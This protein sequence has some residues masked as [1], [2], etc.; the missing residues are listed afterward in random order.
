MDVK[1]LRSNFAAVERRAEFAVTYF[2]SHLFWHNPGVR[3]LFPDDIEGMERQRDR[4][5]AALTHVVTHIEDASLPRYLRDL[6]RDHRKFL[7][8]PEHYAAVGDSLLAALAKAAGSAWTPE[9]EKAWAEAYAMIADAMMAGAEE[10]ERAGEPP[11]WDAE[12]IRHLRYDDDIAV[13]TLRPEVP[14]P[15]TPGQYV[16]V[17]SARVP[18]TWRTYSIANAPRADLTLDLHISRV[19]GGRLSPVLVRELREG[20]V[21]R[22]GAA[23]GA[24]TLRTDPVRPVTLIAAGTGWSPVRAMIEELA[25]RP[26]QPEVRLFAVARDAAYLYDRPAIDAFHQECPWLSVS[27]ITP[28]PGR[29]G[30]EATGRLATALA[31]RVNWAAQDVYLS[32]PAGFIDEIAEVLAGLGADEARI[33]HDSVP[34]TGEERNRPLGTGGWFLARRD[35]RWHNPAGRAPADS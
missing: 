14:L 10:A 24:M 12:V 27:Y 29:P 5:F 22:L 4:L 26:T 6:G 17:S 25:R 8:A 13:L 21:L 2:Y 16:S 15:Y 19:E 34:A 9:A 33:F 23:G 31:T 1:N 11:W 32:G 18:T 3:P 35:P 7:P 20:E 28:A 30:T